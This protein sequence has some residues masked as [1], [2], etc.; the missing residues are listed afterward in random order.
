[1]KR[2][3]PEYP[4]HLTDV[5]A[6]L[7]DS[8]ILTIIQTKDV[9]WQYVKT[10]K[11]LTNLNDDVLSD[12]LN[13][14]VRTFRTYRQPKNKFKESL[15]EHILLL[16]SLFNHGILIFGTPK[17]FDQWLKTKNFFL[18]NKS[19]DTFLFTVTGIRFVDDRL[20]AMEYGD[21]V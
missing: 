13:I 15:K 17:E 20:T 4:D 14:S 1:M 21:N 11:S 18:D 6:I 19:P 9:N 2:S 5:P 12:W 3:S 8:D 10:I 16:L 7:S